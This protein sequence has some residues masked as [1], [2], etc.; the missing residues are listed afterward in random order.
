LP[1][2]YLRYLELIPGAEV[3]LVLDKKK[4]DNHQA[5]AWGGFYRTL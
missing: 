1:E 5:F 4:M 3:E 2:G